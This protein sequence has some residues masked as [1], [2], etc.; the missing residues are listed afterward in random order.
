MGTTKERKNPECGADYFRFD[1]CTRARFDSRAAAASF[2]LLISLYETWLLVCGEV[3]DLRW[4]RDL[5]FIFPLNI[6]FEPCEV[7]AKLGR[8]SGLVGG[9]P[10][11][12]LRRE[13]IEAALRKLLLCWIFSSSLVA[14]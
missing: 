4:S 11:Q 12:G 1:G 13:L 2:F 3:P 7:Q 6:V 14:A 10:N 8:A 9:K 5:L